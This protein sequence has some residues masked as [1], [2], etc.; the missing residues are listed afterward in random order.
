MSNKLGR[1]VY[2]VKVGL[3]T[4]IFD[5]WFD[6]EQQVKGVS[7]AVFRSFTNREDAQKWLDNP[8]A[9]LVK[10]VG[11]RDTS[12]YSS[13]EPFAFVDGSFNPD[14]NVYGYGGFLSVGSDIYLLQ[15]SGDNQYEAALRNV[16]GE[17]LGVEAAL[18]AA[19]D[20]NLKSITIHHDY[21]GLSKWVTGEWK[22]KSLMSQKYVDVVNAAKSEGLEISFEKEAAHTV[23]EGQASWNNINNERADIL[24]KRAVGLDDLADIA[25]R[26]LDRIIKAEGL[27]PSEFDD[28]V[29]HQFT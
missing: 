18:K 16:A 2:A 25:Q 23:A 19:V 15:G 8:N 6:C 9:G 10:R 11:L 12:L 4:G 26:R 24:A 5:T 3:K 17:I 14:T 1:K 13:G 7:G 21:V 22:A 20:L 28:S 27:K 29:V